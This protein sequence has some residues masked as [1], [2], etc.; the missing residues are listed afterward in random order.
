MDEAGGVGEVRVVA[1]AAGVEAAP[2]RAAVKKKWAWRAALRAVHRD[3]GYLAVGLTIVYAI[4]GIAVNHIADWDPNFTQ[5]KR[6]LEVPG[7][8]ADV[9]HASDEA[10]AARALAELGVSEVPA[11]IYRAAPTRLDIALA[12]SM[13]HVNPETGIIIEEGQRARPLVRAFNWLH[14]NRGKAAWTLFADGFAVML[15]FLALSGMFM[16][17]GKKG[18]LGRGAFLVVLG[19]A[20][21]IGYVWLSGGP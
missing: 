11:D 3:V 13:V 5:F 20:I 14:L 12:K 7:A 10:V 8:F 17:K 21:P 2:R 15:L 18:L 16:L 9:P 4:S 19:A 6:T 1:E